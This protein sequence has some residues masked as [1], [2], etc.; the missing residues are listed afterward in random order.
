MLLA[1]KVFIEPLKFNINIIKSYYNK[2]RYALDED[3]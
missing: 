1:N 2:S 3:T